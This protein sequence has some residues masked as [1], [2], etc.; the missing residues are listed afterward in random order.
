VIGRAGGVT[1]HAYL[2]SAAF[3]RELPELV[4]SERQ[5]LGTDLLESI[6]VVAEQYA[7]AEVA[8][9]ASNS[10]ALKAAASRISLEGLSDE[11]ATA[12]PRE[13]DALLRSRRIPI[14][15]DGILHSNASDPGLKDGD[16]LYLPQRPKTVLVTGAVNMPS[17]FIWE[18]GTRLEDCIARAGGF[19][20]DAAEDHT[21]V[22]K[23]NGEL[24]KVGSNTRLQVG[25]MVVVPNKAIVSKPGA[26]DRFLSVVQTVANGAFIFRAFR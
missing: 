11:T 4:R 15:L 16:V 24:I 5:R 14:D 25:D 20:R 23:V 22:L 13:L 7:A 19:A 17:A 2:P 8:R 9:Q 6:K 10:N 26:F 21:M 1:P 12:L 18:T 3:T